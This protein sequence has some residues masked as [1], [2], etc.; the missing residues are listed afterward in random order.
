MLFRFFW[1]LH[2]YL[3][4]TRIFVEVILFAYCFFAKIRSTNR[5]NVYVFMRLILV[6][7][8]AFL[9]SGGVFSIMAS[10]IHFLKLFHAM[11]CLILSIS[12]WSF[13]LLQTHIAVRA[14]LNKRAFFSV[15]FVTSSSAMIIFASWC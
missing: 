1:I 13:S 7:I 8:F 4:N 12:I 11:N 15:N 14:K 5:N 2:V 6:S 3:S 9:G 10:L